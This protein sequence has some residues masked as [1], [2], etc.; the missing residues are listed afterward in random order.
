MKHT[1]FITTVALCGAVLFCGCSRTTAAALA[2]LP[3]EIH[4]VSVTYCASDEVSWE[5]T[6]PE[7]QALSDWIGQLLLRP[8]DFREGETPFETVAGGESYTFVINDGESTFIYADDGN[9]YLVTGETWYSIED[10]SPLPLT[11]PGEPLFFAGEPVDES[12]V[13]QETVEWLRWYNSLPEEEQLAVSAVPPDLL[14]ESGIA[15]TED[16]EAAAE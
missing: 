1:C 3:D 15:E 11:I 2:L 10:P 16:A 8:V 9:Q 12:K 13:S 6:A 7:I 5:L 14:E 4:S